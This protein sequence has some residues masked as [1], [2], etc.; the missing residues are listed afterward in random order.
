MKYKI[1]LHVGFYSLIEF[2]SETNLDFED[3]TTSE[4]VGNLIMK[5]EA[6]DKVKNAVFYMRDEYENFTVYRES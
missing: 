2:E 1:E 5:A 3:I 6:Q 4:E